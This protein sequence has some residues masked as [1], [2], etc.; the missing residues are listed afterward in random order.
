[1]FP[2]SVYGRKCLNINKPKNQSITADTR[3][4]AEGGSTGTEEHSSRISKIVFKENPQEDVTKL[5]STIKDMRRSQII[6]VQ[7]RL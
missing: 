3:N 1:M 6:G 5:Q 7:V 4:I 2:S